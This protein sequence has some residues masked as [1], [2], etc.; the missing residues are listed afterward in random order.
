MNESELATRYDASAVESKWYARWEEAGLFKP[1]G[2]GKPFTITI[3][4]P[5]ITGSLHMGHALCYPIQDALGRFHRLLGDDVLIVPGQDHAGIATQSVVDKQL[6]KEGQSAAGLGREKFLEKVWE[7]RKLSGDTILSQ[8]RSLGCAFDWSQTRFTLDEKYAKAVLDVFINWFDRGLIFRGKRVVNWDPVL[9]TSVSDIETE[10]RAVKGKLYHVRYRFADGSGEIVVATTR[11]ETI[12]AD[13]AVAVHPSDSRYRGLAGKKLLNP[14]TDEEIPLIEDVYPDPEFG[15][16]A[17]KIT[18]AHDSNDFLVGTRHQLAM[19]TCIDGRGK[20]TE[21]AGPLAGMD[22][23]EA[24]TVSA[25]ILEDSELLVKAEDYEIPLLV[26]E[27]SGEPIEPLLSE[28]WFVDQPKLAGSVLMAME[29]GE[30]SFIPPR[31]DRIFV[32]WMENIREWCISRQLWWGHRIPVY[33]AEDGTCAAA[34]SADEAAKKMGKPVVRQD[35]DVLDTWFSSGLWPFAVLGWPEQ[36]AELE[37][38]YPTSVLITDRNII[39]LWVARMAMMG[40]DLVGKKPFGDVMIYATVQNEHG[41]RMSKSLGTG[42]DPMGIIDMVGADALRWTLQSQT[43]ENQDLRFSP[44]KTEDARNFCNKVWNAARFILMNMGEGELDLNVEPEGLTIV[45]RWLLSRLAVAESA[46]RE[47]FGRCDFQS[48]CQILYRFFWDDLCDWYIE[49]SK[50]RL[51]SPTEADAPRWCLLNAIEAFLTMLHPIMPHIS[52]EL[53]SFLPIK[54]KT[55]FLMASCWPDRPSIRIDEEAESKVSAVFDAVR[56]LRSLRAAIGISPMASAPRACF[57]GDLH[58]L[59]DVVRFLSW[60]DRLDSGRPDEKSL[61]GVSFGVRLYLPIPEGTNLEGEVE[62]AQR[63]LDKLGKEHTQLA[64]RLANP[65]FVER[66]KPEVVAKE[67]QNLE[68]LENRIAAVKGRI[69][70]LS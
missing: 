39:N 50:R 48:A 22:R 64:N 27:R 25:K 7:W 35:D 16:G 24:R 46:V 69:Q 38:R 9:Q 2:S 57:D 47:A 6:K 20:M 11:P 59:E 41:Q 32:D 21:I 33:Y 53:F 45:D 70:V 55:E 61:E 62:K 65:Q 23:F 18:P 15:T 44:R 3:P 52:E 13:V 63:E 49:A 5:N 14:L 26:S 30:I 1:K 66:A 54:G 34:H 12:Y 60:F 42:V 4:P 43:G 17:L 10:R 51:S 28:Q 40:L 58:G 31:Y 19:P 29:A 8:L 67:R 36:S 56:E 68:S 37:R